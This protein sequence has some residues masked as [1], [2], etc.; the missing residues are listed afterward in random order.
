MPATSNAALIKRDRTAVSIQVD[1]HVTK[2]RSAIPATG[3]S[4]D[5]FVARNLTYDKLEHVC[6]V[7]KSKY[8]SNICQI[9]IK[10]FVCIILHKKSIFPT[11]MARDRG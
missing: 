6:F 8:I 1:P 2:L 3:V 4:A 7:L 9:V 10:F 5:A 11:R